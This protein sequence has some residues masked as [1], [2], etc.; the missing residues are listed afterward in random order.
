MKNLV[1]MKVGWNIFKLMEIFRESKLSAIITGIEN[2]KGI[3]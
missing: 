2:A 3:S 1:V